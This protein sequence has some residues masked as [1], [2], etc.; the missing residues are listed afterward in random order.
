MQPQLKEA[1]SKIE[2]NQKFARF[3]EA[4]KKKK[5]AGL[6]DDESLLNSPLL[7][8]FRSDGFMRSLQYGDKDKQRYAY[9]VS[10]RIAYLGWLEQH[11]PGVAT[12]YKQL[13]SYEQRLAYGASFNYFK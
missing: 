8:E 2:A 4:N 13:E 3:Y 9:I 12:E 10:Q 6:G 5:Y 11:V 1:S 7:S